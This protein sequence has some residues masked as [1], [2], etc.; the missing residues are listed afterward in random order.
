[1]AATDVHIVGHTGEALVIERREHTTEASV[2]T[3]REIAEWPDDERS[4]RAW[5][6]DR[7][8]GSRI[9]RAS[10]DDPTIEAER[11]RSYVNGTT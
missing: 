5:C 2:V 7:A 10:D 1:M 11:F 6:L 3:R 9:I 8:L 4:Q